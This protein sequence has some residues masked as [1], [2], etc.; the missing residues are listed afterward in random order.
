MPSSDRAWTAP[1]V[2]SAEGAGATFDSESV[3][4]RAQAVLADLLHRKPR[5]VPKGSWHAAV[6]YSQGRYARGIAHYADALEQI[7]FSG[8]EHVLDVG[9][10]AGHWCIALALGND[11]VDGIELRREYVDVARAVTKELGLSDRVKYDVANA[12]NADLPGEHY[13]LACCHSVLMFTDHER[14]LRNIA[15]WLT[16]GGRLYCGYTTAG[17]RV[18]AAV[19][20]LSQND[21]DRMQV[22]VGIFVSDFLFRLGIARTRPS[23]VR[24]FL[25]NELLALARL[26]GFAEA[27]RPGI[28]DGLRSYLGLPG[29][30]DFVL[31]KH[32]D[33]TGPRTPDASYIRWLVDVGAPEAA[34][35]HIEAGA[36]DPSNPAHA[37]TCLRAFIKA[38][39]EMDSAATQAFNALRDTNHNHQ[40]RGMYWH[41]RRN[42]KRA[43]PEY[44]ALARSP[45]RAFLAGCALLELGRFDQ[46]LARLSETPPLTARLPL[47]SWS[48]ISLT[49]L[50]AGDVQ[51]VRTATRDLLRRLQLDGAPATQ[52]ERELAALS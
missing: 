40:I 13:D 18:H 42:I 45:D 19:R 26:W 20:A 7:G 28:Q 46:A 48:S 43:L 12:E 30:V 14:V 49:A 27:A 10:G 39:R 24:V 5:T 21:L 2:S 15:R 16:P 1:P 47:R 41:S 50:L 29:T 52:V 3:T 35:D 8:T 6:T 51:R 22:Q 17:S 38:Q 9:S 32:P 25:P 36:L 44:E 37:P 11:R 23:Q 31:T 34:L 33:E 4:E